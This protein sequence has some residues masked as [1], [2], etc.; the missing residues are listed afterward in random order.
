MLP[1]YI[2][3]LREE[4]FGA[5]PGS[6]AASTPPGGDAEPTRSRRARL[7]G[8]VVAKAA[9]TATKL[10]PLVALLDAIQ[11][12]VASESVFRA[13][14]KKIQAHLAVAYAELHGERPR[15]Q[16]L[17]HAFQTLAD[18]VR[19]ETRDISP[20]ELKQAAKEVALATLKNAPALINAAHQARLLS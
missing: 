12:Q 10:L 8:A 4:A 15:R 1:V 16:A 9:A 6:S 17:S 20:D 18:L 7:E 14:R 3:L 11:P 19:E 5:P 2:D 13:R